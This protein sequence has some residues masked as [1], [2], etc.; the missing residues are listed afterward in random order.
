MRNTLF[1]GLA[2]AF[3]CSFTHPSQPTASAT[4]T[5]RNPAEDPAVP[6]LRKFYQDYFSAFLLDDTQLSEK[7]LEALKKE[8]CSPELLTK[9]KNAKL[10]YDVFIDAQDASDNAA[11]T[12]Q[13]HKNEGSGRY[14][15][16]YTSGWS[17]QIVQINVT[18]KSIGGKWMINNIGE[19]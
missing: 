16:Y 3:L 2:I 17:N 10:D 19:L 13:V 5:L 18:V 8:S 7:K 12:I 11:S 4:T 14:V 15:V 6:F 1:S 9:L